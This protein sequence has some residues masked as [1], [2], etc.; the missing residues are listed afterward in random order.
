MV[1]GLIE[2]VS[3][4]P[5]LWLVCASSGI[6]VPVPEDVPLLFAGS[7]IAD[8]SW[9]WPITL[10]VAWAGVATR[11]AGAWLFGR[12]VGRWMLDENRLAW[13]LATR[14]IARAR[15]L[16][17]K[18]GTAAVL[19]GRFMVGF[20]SPVFMAAGAM[21]VPLRSFVLVDGLGLAVAVPLAVG[22]GYVFGHPLAELATVVLQ[23]TTNVVGVAVILAIVWFG[24]R[25][26][27]TD[28]ARIR[29]IVGGM[30]GRAAS[31]VLE[32]DQGA[33]LDLDVVLGT[34]DLAD[35]D[36]ETV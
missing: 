1:Q 29:A 5:G 27:V 18:H 35:K 23:R 20:R 36:P 4:Y 33:I 31:A 30:R 15:R 13:L 2:S 6:V 21:G 26:M 32:E 12:I 17:A 19:L 9:S 10:V 22:L 24:W 14:R 25:A 7:R 11:D 16:V 28:R 3:G 8:G 34:P